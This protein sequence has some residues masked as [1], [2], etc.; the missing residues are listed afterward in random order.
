M[1]T[2]RFELA[3]ESPGQASHGASVLRGTFQSQ[4]QVNDL[5]QLVRDGFDPADFGDIRRGYDE[6]SVS[7]TGSRASAT[8]TLPASEALRAVGSVRY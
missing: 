3:F 6:A 4:R 5:G 1:A 8:L 2:V 7:E